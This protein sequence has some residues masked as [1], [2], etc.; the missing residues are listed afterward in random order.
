MVKVH[1][2]YIRRCIELAL[3]GLGTTYPNPM[4]GA[5]IVHDDIIIGEGWHRKAGEPHA[6]VNAVN[7]VADT[8]LLKAATIYVSLEPCSHFGRTP[9][10]CDLILKTGIPNIVVGTVD[11]FSK[12]SGEGIRKLREAGRNVIVGVLGNECRKLNRR[13]FTF[14]E[15]KRPYVILKWAQSKDGYIAPL[16]REERRPVWISTEASRRLAHKWRTEEQA[17]LVGTQTAADDDPKLDVR[18]WNGP[19]P[20][21]FAIDRTRRIPSRSAL[22]DQK[23]PTVVITADKT[24]DD[25]MVSYEAASFENLASEV[26]AIAYRRGIQSIIIEGGRHTLQTFIDAGMWDEARIITGN[27][28]LGTGIPAPKLNGSPSETHSLDGDLIQ[29]HYHDR[30]HYL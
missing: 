27:V 13:F 16:H 7:S 28:M 20:V 1:E 21:R 8:S 5:V 25:G 15:E 22:F 2:K 24:P 23:A 9:P 18:L 14:H 3:N 30:H 12:V 4:V 11:T 19:Q 10:C 6:E 26:L 17:I 29:I